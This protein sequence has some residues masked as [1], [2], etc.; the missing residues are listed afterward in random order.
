[1]SQQ[2]WKVDDVLDAHTSDSWAH[3]LLCVAAPVLLAITLVAYVPD[4]H[5]PMFFK[6]MP[7]GLLAIVSSIFLVSGHVSRRLSVDHI[8][9]VTLLLIGWVALSLMWSSDRLGGID[10]LAKFGALGLIFLALRHLNSDSALKW[11]GIAITVAVAT[12]PVMELLSIA[13]FG[14]YY[15]QNFE[16]ETILFALPFMF[17]EWGRRTIISRLG[18]LVA[19]GLIGYLVFLNPSK[20]EFLVLPMLIGVFAVVLLRRKT[21]LGAS[22]LLLAMIAAIG[23]LAWFGWDS[24]MLKASHGF[25]VSVYP[26]IELALNTLSMWR[27]API[28]G[29]GAGSFSYLYPQYQTSHKDI[30]PFGIDQQML[31]AKTQ[32]AGASHNEYLQLAS[33]YGLV[34]VL[35]ALALLFFTL[36]QSMRVIDTNSA[37]LIGL[38]VVVIG[39][40]SAL[41]EFPLQNPATALLWVVGAAWLTIH[42]NENRQAN[43]QKPSVASSRPLTLSLALVTGLATLPIALGMPRYY[44]A[45][46]AF[47][48][49]WK[50]YNYNP[51]AALRLNML[52]VEKY[53]F[54]DIFRAQLYITLVRG[55]ELMQQ[56]RLPKSDHD[57]MFSRSVSAGT[58]TGLIMARLQYLYNAGLFEEKKAE[59][60]RWRE[61]LRPRADQTPDI[62]L[63]ESVFQIKDGDRTLAKAALDRYL[64][65]TDGG[66]KSKSS[67]IEA[68]KAELADLPPPAA[69]PNTIAKMKK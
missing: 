48:G 4:W 25:K 61:L 53:P 41:I 7:I 24:P 27:E 5:T 65:L 28:L 17:L 20:I 58:N 69:V 57:A 43:D 36:R 56:V 31:A 2:G 19:I 13:T 6:W 54:D 35:I 38:S 59:V 42:G 47:G 51:D 16:T 55:D 62:W 29:Q 9:L 32:L 14:G 60:T 3:A 52:A 12:V 30:L 33:N 50:N 23:V 64:S 40:V 68:L 45:N 15:N 46:E 66:Q 21:L 10:T 26:R 11:I 37:G 22:G 8:D 1:M 44:S 63:M 67:I 34:G 18:P 49:V 39:L